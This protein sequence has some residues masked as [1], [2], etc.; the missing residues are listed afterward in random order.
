MAHAMVCG[1]DRPVLRGMGGVQVGALCAFATLNP[2]VRGVFVTMDPA[3][4]R[5]AVVLGGRVPA[6]LVR[7]EAVVLVGPGARAAADCIPSAFPPPPRP[8]PTPPDAPDAAGTPPR[9]RASGT[10]YWLRFPSQHDPVEAHGNAVVSGLG[11][12]VRY[13]IDGHVC[14]YEWRLVAGGPRHVAELVW[15]RQDGGSIRVT[16]RCFAAFPPVATFTYALA[17]NAWSSDPENPT[18]DSRLDSVADGIAE[19]PL[20]P[21]EFGVVVCA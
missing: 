7:R 15:A 12:D 13:G 18:R 17:I 10:V 6:R 3:D 4:R 14:V 11:L 21:H 20:L 2:L 8:F 16:A 9:N 1:R 5:V 19:P